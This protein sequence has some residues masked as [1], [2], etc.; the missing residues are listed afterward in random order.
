MEV[1]EEPDLATAYL[2]ALSGVSQDRDE[3]ISEFMYRVR[4]L[5]IKAHPSLGHQQRERILVTSFLLGL[6]DR[7]LASSLAVA[8]IQTAAE[9]E[10]L[11]A[12][13]E[14]VRKDQRGRKSSFN[15]LRESL[16]PEDVDEICTPGES[17]DSSEE[18]EEL[19]AAL[20]SAALTRRDDK[21][22]SS[23]QLR[24]ATSSTRCYGCGKLGHYRADCTGR[25]RSS[26][27]GRS[28]ARNFP[29]SC[30]ICG[31]RHLVRNCPQ[32][33]IARQAAKADRGGPESA[34]PRKQ[35]RPPA[36][37]DPGT[38]FKLDG[39]AVLVD[40]DDSPVKILDSTMAAMSEESTPGTPRML[41]FFV[42]GTIQ[43]TPVWILADS[44]SVRNLIDE[45]LFKRL[46][47]QP[48]I[49]DP[50]DV[51]VISGSGDA[52]ELKG[53]AV[54]PVSLGTTLV[55]HEFGVVP[56]L[57]LEVLIGADVFARHQCSLQYLPH[58]RKRLQ[59][60][61][62]SCSSCDRFRSDPRC[63]APAQ[64]RFV[65]R[66]LKRRRN[67]ARIGA[68]F[69][70]TLP[71][72][73]ESE[74]ET[75]EEEHSPREEQASE[76]NLASDTD[77][78]PGCSSPQAPPEPVVPPPPAIAEAPS[79]DAEATGKLQSVLADLRVASLPIE[80]RTKQRLINVVKNNL[81]A[82]AASPTDLGRTSVVV[83]T[84]KTGEARP[85]RH[86]LRPIP[87][88]RRQFLEQEVEKLL[89]I[90]AISHA[91]PGACPY[92]S[93]TVI[94]PKK[95]GTLRM[96]VDYRD[97][98]A[99]TEKDSFP[100]PRIDQVWPTLANARYFASLDLLM[101][102]HQ[103][104]VDPKDRAKT[105]FL[106]HRGLYVYNVMPFGLCNAPATF[107][108]LMEKV[109][110][111]H[112][113]VGVLVYLDDVLIYAE[114][115]E[116]LIEKLAE[117]LQLLARAG[118][119]CKAK[120][121]SLFT[122]QV[123]YLGHYI[124]REGIL[125]EPGKLEKIK[126]W[127]KPD[128]GI[129]MAS[130]LGYCNYYR[131]LIPSFAH[132]SDSLYKASR[133]AF[134]EWTPSLEA[135]FEQLKQQMLTPRI[136]RM[137]DPQ[138]DF[139][140]ETDGSRIALGAVLKQRFDD[141][142]LE[143]PVGFFSRSLTGSER[144]YVAYELELYAVVRAVEHFRMFLLGREFLLRTDHAALRNLLRRD[145]PPTTRVERWIL[146]LSEYTFRIE[147]Q[148][149]QNNVVADVLSRL[150]FATAQELPEGEPSVAPQDCEGVADSPDTEVELPEMAPSLDGE[151]ATRLRTDAMLALHDQYDGECSGGTSSDSE[152]DLDASEAEGVREP[153]EDIEGADGVW[154][155]GVASADRSTPIVDMPISREGTTAEDFSIPGPEEF[156]TEQE[157]DTELMQLRAWVN[158]GQC[159]SVDSLAP[160]SS[161]MKALA[162]VF[163]ETHIKE[164][165]LV[166]RRLDDPERDLIIVP[167]SR[168]ENIIR[169]FH[170][171]P[172]GAHQA[173]K[174]TS[175]KIIR[176]FWWPDLKRDVRI[177]IACCP[178]C[179]KFLR[180]NRTPRAGL[181]PMEIGG[182]GDCLAMDIVGGRDSLPTTPRGH[183]YILT[184]IDCF[185]RYAIAIP[186]VDQSTES[187]ISALIG[188]LITV[189]GTP[190]RI[191]TDQG[192]NFE[193][194]QFI[195]FCNLFRI[196][197]IRTSAYHPQSNGVCER[198]NQTL[199]YGLRKSLSESQYC[200]WDLYLNFVVF[201]Y[202]LS[203]HSSTGFSPFYLT[204]G[205]E[206]RLPSD[207]IFGSPALTQDGADSSR[208]P[209]SLLLKSFSLLSR[210]FASVRVNL[211]SFHQREKDLYD[212]GAIERIF[213]PGDTVRVRLKARQRGPAK[214]NTE[215]S[216]PH[217]VVSVRGVVVTL[218][219]LSSGREYITH[220]DRLSNPILSGKR[221]APQVGTAE[222][223]S[224]NANPT[225]NLEEPPE[226]D[227]PVANPEEALI[228]TRY[229]RVVKPRRDRDFEYVFMLPSS[230]SHSAYRSPSVRVPSSTSGSL[231]QFAFVPSSQDSSLS[232]LRFTSTRVTC[233]IPQ[234]R[235]IRTAQR[236]RLENLGE[237]VCWVVDENGFDQQAVMLKSNGTILFLDVRRADWFSPLDGT[238]LTRI[239]QNDP[240]PR[241]DTQRP[242][243][244]D[245]VRLP[246]PRR[247]VSWRRGGRLHAPPL[248]LQET[249]AGLR[250][251]A[252]RH[253][254]PHAPQHARQ[255]AHADHHAEQRTTGGG[256]PEG[257]A[258]VS[259]LSTE[260]DVQ[261]VRA[262]PR[263][264]PGLAHCGSPQLEHQNAGAPYE[265]P[266][267]TRAR[268]F[269]PLFVL[270]RPLHRILRRANVQLVLHRRRAIS[271]SRRLGEGVLPSSASG[272]DGD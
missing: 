5:V 259:D 171:G 106:T 70:A 231:S 138:R 215:W 119:K 18:E 265:L 186:L 83:H 27:V 204:F 266:R 116:Q 135:N 238:S 216:G 3:S 272:F 188:N 190:R 97:M 47:F 211:H 111:H 24:P 224:R 76:A 130:F 131:D 170:E 64:M 270:G 53:F 269:S 195:S 158:S 58:N 96:C 255:A 95:D 164:G 72:V 114:T 122:E 173:P 177:Y 57:P 152:S 21:T 254:R 41:L 46:P 9:A 42:L 128:K 248:R 230:T 257:G 73:A 236:M 134:I 36:Q 11:A 142:N 45:A 234:E 223:P 167:S 88:A 66:N 228:R 112:I 10:R 184:I 139:I 159:P 44:G 161:R 162:Q 229:G 80:E 163:E 220:H 227:E 140:L 91:D 242:L 87:F 50:G 23:K 203:V 169:F 56:N 137:P 222:E 165:V 146:R 110:G 37:A 31:E 156:Q 98:N 225:E 39:T 133:A 141:T 194:E 206:A 202:N 59:F 198:F 32:L 200:S 43:T 155:Q 79:A 144:N 52:L 113:G 15:Y 207:L 235:S 16:S 185:T 108:R 30:L 81:D 258:L 247:A 193:S 69:V 136:V 196:S 212:L 151:K 121:C 168:V 241:L 93:R 101:G 268:T 246:V 28:P 34:E 62:Q 226:D 174:A 208:G 7:Q 157:A 187:I 191:L 117:V 40:S 29:L 99:Q 172:G 233:S 38:A 199:K 129:G 217:E 14:A 178:T 271:L 82:F 149:G 1:F 100:L 19:S 124:S 189:Y 197:K 12:E 262:G 123:H 49:R 13:G 240:W 153:P 175:A 26:S 209:L 107:Q 260:D 252:R 118:L 219:E 84:I 166:L 54:L 33:D 115:P 103:V 86:K 25:P 145:L 125:P 239:Q 55:W 109:L 127:P 51:R 218:R 267:G 214:F 148:K 20:A 160:M 243:T 245:E 78:L 22:S 256:G 104:E 90:G 143:H 61:L 68:N 75:D 244:D 120:K 94:A 6:H 126:Q 213:R 205:S 2:N 132:L 71:E 180:I 60:G 4:L 263:I 154:F 237:Q 150:P 264:E 261:N 232:E 251:G 249:V 17:R 179:E 67:R 253:R 181:R 210:A 105:A 65:D 8:K 48:N 176:C 85:F 221:L 77:G 89:A 35:F 182:R 74:S 201:S 92:A 250:E 63:G 147:Y 192:R 102:Y 183:K